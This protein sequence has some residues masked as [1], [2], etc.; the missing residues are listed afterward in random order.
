MW[1]MLDSLQHILIVSQETQYLVAALALAGS[2][3]L[4]HFTGSRLLAAIF[5]P[6]AALGALIGIYI[7]RELGVFLA[8]DEDSNVVLSGLVGLIV[9]V[10]ILLIITRLC[11][12]AVNAVRTHRSERLREDRPM[13]PR[14]IAQ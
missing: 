8:T 6:V 5:A 9:G 11:Y 12:N 13:P 14:D 3:M 10:L 2:L 1:T 7:C 4:L